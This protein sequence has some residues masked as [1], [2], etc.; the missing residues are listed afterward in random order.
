[1]RTPRFWQAFSASA[2]AAG[3]VENQT[4]LIRR[5]LTRT[6]LLQLRREK[7]L[8]LPYFPVNIA[9]TAGQ[10]RP[11][12]TARMRIS[13]AEPMRKSRTIIPGFLAA[14]ASLALA[15]PSRAADQAL[16]DAAKKEGA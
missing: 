5:S 3:R 8:P 15:A 10:S 2:S 9:A 11:R 12:F 1:M 14:A 6:P 4:S 7:D 13:G 16:I